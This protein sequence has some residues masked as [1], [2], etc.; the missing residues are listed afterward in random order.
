MVISLVKQEKKAAMFLINYIMRKNVLYFLLTIIGFLLMMAC[1]FNSVSINREQDDVEGQAFLKR[2]YHGIEKKEFN[3]LDST[4]DD[5]LKRL[6]G[7]NGVSK[8][9]KFINKK[10]GDY[11]SYHIEDRYIRAVVGSNNGV[12]YNYKL[13]VT[14][15]KGT[16][17]E[18]IG[19]KKQNGSA[20]K[21]NSYHANS[22][23]LMN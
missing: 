19:F 17:D 20:I 22:D 16:I 3:Y 10:V 14:Y 1:T 11:K 21:I 2:Y 12:F 7:P 23:L 8:L 5:S 9:V 15:D 13:K 6:V 4:E 18:I